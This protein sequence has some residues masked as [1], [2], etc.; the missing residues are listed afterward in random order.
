MRRR[1]IA[2][3]IVILFVS[4]QWFD[5]VIR[6]A[7]AQNPTVLVTGS[8]R[9]I[10][11]EFVK[12]YAAE[13]WFVI[14]TTRRPFQADQ[15]QQLA[16][17]NNNITI[18]KLD[19]TSDE[20]LKTLAEKYKQRPI[21]V[22]INNAGVSGDFRGPGQQFGS[23]DYTTV[24]TFMSVNAVGPIRVAEAFYENVKMSRQKKIIAIT[25]LLGVHSFEYGGFEGAYWYK[26]SKAAMNAAMY[27]LATEAIADTI[28]VVML[29]PGEVAVEKVENPGPQFITP[30]ESI[31]GMIR[32]IDG[33]TIGDSGSIISHNGILH[34]F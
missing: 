29:T 13:G 3:S 16:R 22:L 1:L 2:I 12:Q 17:N 15:L 25:A 34:K 26:I 5:A 33:L 23:L 24:A 6:P 8:N 9:G 14:A 4:N 27:N 20:H 19:V 10:G 11:L 28:T 7:H 31:R 21:D 18:E 32:V 30:K